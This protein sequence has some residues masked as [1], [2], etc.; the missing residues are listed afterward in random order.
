M[1][2]YEFEVYEHRH[3]TVGVQAVSREEAEEKIE[4][5]LYDIDMDDAMPIWDNREWEY[6][7]TTIWEVG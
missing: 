2:M 4:K 6:V 1:K 5:I 7:Q 3:K